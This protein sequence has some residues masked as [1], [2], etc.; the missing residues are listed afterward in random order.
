MRGKAEARPLRLLL[1][2]DSSD[3]VELF[4]DSLSLSG[5]GP[6]EVRP[7]ASLKAALAALE[8]GPA[9]DLVIA[10]LGLPDNSG[11]GLVRRL[12]AACPA[13]ILVLTGADAPGA[14]I[15]AVRLGAG[16]FLQK[17]ACTPG[18]LGR[19]I[20]YA[21]ERHRFQAGLA[22]LEALRQSEELQRAFVANVSHE[23]RT[24]LAVVLA[25]AE[26]LRKDGLKTADGMKLVRMIERHGH[27][28][29]HLVENLLDLSALEAGRYV[30]KYES[31]LLAPL[32][33]AHAAG[34]L[35]AHK[36]GVSIRVKIAAGLRVVA[37]AAQLA[38]VA[39]NLCDNALK[40]NRR[41]G[42]VLIE[43]R[44]LKDETVVSVKD[45]GIGIAVEDLARVFDRFRRTPGAVLKSPKGSGL[46]LAIVKTIVEAHG[47]R[48]WVESRL[49]KG[50]TFSFSLPAKTA[51]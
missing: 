24:P 45:S 8:A 23:L 20:T 44:D 39:Q 38:Q 40:Y 33:R 31:I 15:E 21:L 48:I 14:G 43:A 7:H 5:V 19:A 13:P 51:A 1:I 27:R 22:E 50:S 4:K 47:G 34:A 26:T 29:D 6:V 36:Q 32:I 46:G 35:L 10:D 28:L 25:C 3:D 2:E 16:D 37:D 41:G 17:D 9:P 11:P 12:R 30:P 49:G 42:S 18:A